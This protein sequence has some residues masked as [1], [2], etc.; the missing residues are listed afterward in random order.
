[1]KH[2]A[3]NVEFSPL[4][5][6]SFLSLSLLLFFSFSLSLSLSLS[7]LKKWTNMAL[8]SHSDSQIFEKD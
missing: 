4:F 7:L 3:G 2:P 1:M 5:F 6:P 8:Q